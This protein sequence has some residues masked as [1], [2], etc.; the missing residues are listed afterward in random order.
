MRAVIKTLQV[1]MISLLLVFAFQ[2]NAQVTLFSEGSLTGNLT[3]TVRNCFTNAVMA[4]VPVSCGGVG[5][6]LTNAGGVYT[7]NGIN[8]GAQTVTATFG[9]FQNYSAAVMVVGNTTTTYNF[10]MNPMPAVLSGIVTNCAN[11]NSVVGVKVVLYGAGNIYTYSVNGGHYTLNLFP[12]GTFPATFTKVGFGDSTIT[13]ITVSPPDTTTLNICLNGNTPPPSPTIPGTSLFTAAL[14]AGQTAVNLNWGLPVDDMVLIYD[15]GIQDN[16]AIWATG[17]GNNLNAM[18]FTPISYPAIVKGFYVNIGTAVNYLT[19]NAFSPVQMAIYSEAGGLPGAQLSAPVTITPTVYGWTQANFDAPVTLTSG[20]FFIVMIQLGNAASSPGIAIDTTIQ[21]LRSYSKFGASPWLPGPGNFMIRAIVNGSGGPLS[22]GDQPAAPVT[23]SA[24]PNLIY[25][26]APATITGAEGSPMVYPEMGFNPDNLLSYQVWRLRQNQHGTPSLWFSVGTTTNIHFQDNSWP[27]DT[28]G[29]YQWATK[30]QYTFNRWSDVTFS[31]AIGKCWTCNATVNVDLSCDSA[32]IAGAVVKFQNLDVDTSYTYMMTTTGTHTFAN[33]WKGNYTLTVTKF[34]YTTYTQTPVSI[35]GD[36]TFNV[37]LLQFKSPPTGLYVNDT[38]LFGNWRAPQYQMMLFNET[39]SSGSFT[40]NAWVPDAGSHWAISAGNGN[41]G[42][43]AQWN[44][45]LQVTDYNQSLTSKLITGVYSPVMKLKYDIHLDNF[46]TTTLE[47]LAV[48]IWDGAIWHS[49]KNYDNSTGSDIPYTTETIDI[50]PYANTSFKIRFRAYGSDSNNIDWWDIDNIQVLSQTP[51][52]NPDPCIFGYNFYLNNILDGFTPDTFYNIPKTHVEY[53]HFYHA[54]VLAIYASGYSTTSSFDFTSHLLYPPTNVQALAMEDAAYISWNKPVISE[55]MSPNSSDRVPATGT[56]LVSDIAPGN[57]QGL[58]CHDYIPMT[59]ADGTYSNGTIINSPGTGA[60]GADESINE[61][62][63]YGNNANQG[64]GYSQ[65][66]DFVVPAGAGWDVTKLTLYAYQTYAPSTGSITG[67]FLRIYDGAPNGGGTVVWGDLTTNR[68]TAQTFSDIYRVA[69]AG[70]GTDRAVIKVECNVSSLHLAPGTYWLEF[71]F[72]GSASYTGP[73]VPFLVGATPT[74]PNALQWNGGAWGPLVDYDGVTLRGVPFLVDY[75]G[76]SGGTPAGLMGYRV[77]RDTTFIHYLPSPDSLFYYDLQLNPGFYC[78]DVDAKYD[79]TSYGFP[80]IFAYS[81]V[82]P[83]GPA[84]VNVADGYPLPFFE[85]WDQA[86]FT[87]Q[88]WT[89]APSQGNWSLNTTF[90]NPSPCADFS[91]QPT[92]TNYDLSL[93]SPT[94]N[95]APWTCATIWCDF[96][97][98]LVDQNA[99]GDEKLELDILINDNWINK[100]ELTNTVSTD[101]MLKHIDIT[102]AKGQAFKVRFRANSAN[103]ADILHWYVDNIHLYGVCH[104]PETL[105]GYQ[106]QLITTLTWEAPECDSGKLLPNSPKGSLFLGY[107]VWRTPDNETSPFLQINT[108]IVDA[109]AYQ[110]V[111]PGTTGPATTWN[112]YITAVFQDSLN[113]GTNLCEPSSD[114]ITILYPTVGIDDQTN[115]S[116]S[117]YPNPATEIVNIVSTNDIKAVEV[118]NY[119]GQTIYTNKNISLKKVQLNV[120]TFKA[121]VYFMKVTTTDGIRITK[122][123][124][125]H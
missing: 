97:V 47:Q 68:M 95:A 37:M 35:M 77:Y 115:S 38:T 101:W 44:Y 27:S 92:L 81:Q 8:P 111:H 105:S 49:L 11:G 50:T 59:N 102:A 36:M 75:A 104:A 5:P 14:N 41:P 21:Q 69:A 60:G 19:G 93:V 46:G 85:P 91:W 89:F 62:G 110:D 23:V 106:N 58:S 6:V 79:L 10:C 63:S 83:N 30:A 20:N 45:A 119:I 3:G 100:A 96:D 52:V 90:G 42:Q 120:T 57:C 65:A 113:P 2:C 1:L 15:D 54:E 43:C 86:T 28:C 124:V 16:F 125:R 108:G 39:F 29:P 116:L 51:E 25:Q 17:G 40:T 64:A 98:M 32:N 74:P 94:I 88:K 66:D 73:W 121:G 82:A 103:S 31:N 78:Y 56:G 18:K 61:G 99:T 109:L 12:G 84:C 24:V 80:G 76:G 4:N 13:A 122:I 112:Y 22:L 34:G 118:L 33:F 48:E 67:C 9:G 71:Q 26:Y 87:F 114:T 53:G 7:L 107:N 72:T 117:L 123:T 70:G 55:A